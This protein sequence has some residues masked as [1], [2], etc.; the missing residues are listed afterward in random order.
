MMHEYNTCIKYNTYMV[1][2]YVYSENNKIRYIYFKN[3]KILYIYFENN[4]I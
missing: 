4:K 3:N 2:Q 1:H